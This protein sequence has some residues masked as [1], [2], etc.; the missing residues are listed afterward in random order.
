MEKKVERLLDWVRG[1]KVSPITIE[2]NPTERCNLKCRSCWQRANT[3]KKNELSTDKLLSIVKEAAELG[4][5]EFRIPGSGEPFIRNDILDVMR[6]IKK[7]NMYGLLITNGTLLTGEIIEELVRISWDCITFSIDG[8]DSETNDYLRGDGVFEK[9]IKNLELFKNIKKD[10]PLIRFN[11]VLS[12]KNYNRL[13]E[14]I[15]LAHKMGCEDVQFQAMTVW[16]EEGKN[17]LL[18]QKQKKELPEY[19]KKARE[20]AEKYNIFTDIENS[21]ETELID[22]TNKM[23][24]VIREKSN[25][26][27]KFLS[28]PC[29]E[30]FYNM[31]IR[32]DGSVGPCAVFGREESD[33][34]SGKTLQEIWFGN[35]FDKIRE[36]LLNK[37]L[38]SFCKQCCTAVHVENVKIKNKLATFLKNE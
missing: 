16:G 29:F 6:E 18:N 21:L 7:H 23:D 32:P 10:K 22:N 31:I 28:L 2:L 17:L 37:Q 35:V 14:M 12:N 33:S 30:P 4:V 8:P 13:H 26:K 25:D 11:V 15:L 20:F 34:V 9:V 3:T 24:E 27:N 5:K 19:I 1:K 36:S 38:F